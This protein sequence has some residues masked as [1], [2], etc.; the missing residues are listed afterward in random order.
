MDSS[1]AIST[2]LVPIA[3]GSKTLPAMREAWR[4]LL[5]K[6]PVLFA[7]GLGKKVFPLLH[8]AV[9]ALQNR[10]TDAGADSLKLGAFNP[11]FL[12]LHIFTEHYKKPL[13]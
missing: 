6:T 11:Q 1:P 4:R 9:F 3:L 10:Q 12:H 8:E 7:F 13:M 5:K 2:A